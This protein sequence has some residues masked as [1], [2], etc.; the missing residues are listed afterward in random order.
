[1]TD[2]DKKVILPDGSQL[3][4]DGVYR[5]VYSHLRTLPPDQIVELKSSFDQT[6][7]ASRIP[8]LRHRVWLHVKMQAVEQTP[9]RALKAEQEIDM[10]W[11]FSRTERPIGLS[12]HRIDLSNSTFQGQ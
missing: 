2:L 11:Y 12:R 5:C 8:P 7:L 6:L 1:M 3:G 4:K 9:G 10:L